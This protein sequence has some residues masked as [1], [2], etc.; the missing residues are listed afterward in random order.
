MGV[1]PET[2]S[3]ESIVKLL[4]GRKRKTI[5]DK[6]LKLAAVFVPMFIKDG[7]YLVLLTRRTYKVR[8][9]K[10]QISFPG[11]GFHSGEDSDMLDTALRETEEEVGILKGDLSVLGPLDDIRTHSS[12]FIITPYV[13][14]FPYPYD[15]NVNDFEINELIEVPLSTL[16]DERNF[17]EESWVIEGQPYHANLYRCGDVI[18]W[19]ATARI[20]NHFLGLLREILP[21]EEEKREGT[22]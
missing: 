9:H 12:G 4:Q 3:E 14:I 16:L 6:R 8:T 19:G 2:L 15:F 22:V 17:K 21:D 18:I 20:L 13:G 10:G 11:G 1:G 5:S 7:E